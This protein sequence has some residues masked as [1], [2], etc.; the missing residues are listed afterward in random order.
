MAPWL[1]FYMDMGCMPVL[2]AVEFLW[3]SLIYLSVHVCKYV[4]KNMFSGIV[5]V[6]FAPIKVLYHILTWVYHRTHS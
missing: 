3:P 5:Y 4:C 1:Y 2:T 6:L